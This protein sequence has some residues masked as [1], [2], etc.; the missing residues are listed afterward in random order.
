MNAWWNCISHEIDVSK[1]LD[2]NCNIRMIDL[3]SHWVEQIRWYGTLQ[4]YSPERHEQAHN[5]NLKDGWNAS[6]PNVGYLPQVITVSASHSMLRSQG[7]QS[8]SPCSASGEQ[9]C[10]L[11]SPPFWCLSGCPPPIPVICEAWIHV[12]PKPLRWKAS[13]H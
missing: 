10:Q 3:I 8:L 9:L 6:N 11:Q 5:T 1:E 12:T 4:H 13:W 2:A 7:A